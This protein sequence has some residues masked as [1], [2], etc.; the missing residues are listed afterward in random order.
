MS[1][2]FISD[3]CLTISFAFRSL[4]ART[5]YPFDFRIFLDRD[6]SIWAPFLSSNVSKCWFAKMIAIFLSSFPE[7]LDLLLSFDKFSSE[8]SDSSELSNL[9]SWFHHG[10][11]AIKFQKFLLE[12]SVVSHGNKILIVCLT[13]V[14]PCL[15]VSLRNSILDTM[16]HGKQ[17]F[18][19]SNRNLTCLNVLYRV[20]T[21]TWS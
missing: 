15:T 20:L 21:C 13:V 11:M 2:F 3:T 4:K 10:E 14:M 7:K 1:V 16:R 9:S 12:L 17:A 18:T 5:L 6:K 8:S 19:V